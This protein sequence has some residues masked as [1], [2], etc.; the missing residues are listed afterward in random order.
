MH[1]SFRQLIS[2]ITLTLII[3]MAAGFAYAATTGSISGTVVD[4]NDLPLS[5]VTV[6][7]RSYAGNYTSTVTTD[8]SGNYTFPTLS[9]DLFT[10]QF[11]KAGYLSRWNG[12]ATS[13]NTALPITLNA[14]D[15]PTGINVKLPLGGGITGTVV[16]GSGEPLSGAFVSANGLNG[17]SYY[18]TTTDPS[19]NYSFSGME[20]G[21]Y[22]V[23]FS[24]VNYLALWNGGV[25]VKS[26][27]TPVV[28]TPPH[29]AIDINCQLGVGGSISG[30]ITDSSSNPLPNISISLHGP[31]TWEFDTFSTASDA[32]GNYSF[33]GLTNGIYYVQAAYSVWYGGATQQAAQP[34]TVTSPSDVFS[35]INISL[36]TAVTGQGK[37]TGKVVDPND[38]PLANVSLTLYRFSGSTISSVSDANTT[39]DASGNFSFSNLPSGDY[40]IRCFVMGMAETWYDGVLTQQTATAIPVS[41]PNTVSGI[42]IRVGTGSSISGTVTDASG[43]P[44]SGVNVNLSIPSGNGP[45]GGGTTT[46]SNGNYSFKG[47]PAGTYYIQFYPPSPSNSPPVWY[48]GAYTQQTSTPVI[49][50][51][52]VPITGIN[53]R[54]GEGARISGTVRGPLSLPASRAVVAL[55]DQNGT[56]FFSVDADGAGVYRFIGIPA[57]MYFIVFIKSGLRSVWYGDAIAQQ[58]ATPII[59]TASSVVS[60]IDGLLPLGGRISGTVLDAGMSPVPSV[61]VSLYQ[62]DGSYVTNSSTDISGNYS[63]AG[64]SDGQYYLNFSSAGRQKLWYGGSS[65]M[66]ASTPVAVSDSSYL[67]GIDAQLGSGG[68]IS[69][70]ITNGS[71]FMDVNLFDASGKRTAFTRL[72]D[73]SGN[74]SFTGLQTGTYYIRLTQMLNYG[75]IWYGGRIFQN[76]TPVHVTAPQAVHNIDFA[77][78][79]AASNWLDSYVA[80]NGTITGS[81]AGVLC[82]KEIS[83]GCSVAYPPTETVTLTATPDSG[84]YFVGWGADCQG[85]TPTCDVQMNTSHFVSALFQSAPKAK[86]SETGYLTLNFAYMAA[87]SVATIKTLDSILNEDLV[88][89]EDKNI[90][91][92]GGYN[93]QYSAQ[94]GL[95]TILSGSLT[96]RSGRLTVEQL[97]I[98]TSL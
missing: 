84:S 7:V 82:S 64:I 65:S 25:S 48:G 96:V 67:T 89:S 63:L 31:T 58:A 22:Y 14:P 44:L 75:A 71:I 34:I 42:T 4:G 76:A 19:G 39:S 3:A 20:S 62:I 90:S 13:Q 54:I 56:R 45:I 17:G 9:S 23:R 10:L 80:T 86:I 55:Y 2:V 83:A 36:E 85:T 69:G 24:A 11:S 26:L 92:L 21:A 1:K 37:I 5:G 68:S 93:S 78:D 43:I 79:A 61:T 30:T 16:D 49:I 51:G 32:S 72:L 6:T 97:K 77:Y 38:L 18:S 35:G 88:F 8:L 70:T 91:V 94:S 73:S 46:D 29:I 74:Y 47:F 60:G 40:S 66:A 50:S 53:A 59:V 98:R 95:P 41:S 87:G 27:S 15:A 57:G 28:V 81:P 12:G 33:R 52:P